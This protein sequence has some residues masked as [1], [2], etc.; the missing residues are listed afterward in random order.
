LTSA[1]LEFIKPEKLPDAVCEKC[2]KNTLTKTTTVYKFPRALIISLKRFN[3]GSHRIDTD[4]KLDEKLCFCSEGY[5]YNYN[6]ISTIDHHGNSLNSGHY[7]TNVRRGNEWYN[8]NDDYISK[9]CIN[10][11]RHV[12]ILIYQFSL[13]G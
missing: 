3:N 10:S 11:S 1:F 12:Y 5:T 9:T 8:I 6:L 2:L 4:I 13:S 7:T